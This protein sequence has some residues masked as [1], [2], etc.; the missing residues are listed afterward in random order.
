MTRYE[1]TVHY[2]EEL[3]RQS[4]QLYF[5]YRLRHD[6]WPLWLIMAGLLCIVILGLIQ[7]EWSGPTIKAGITLVCFP[8]LILFAYKAHVRLGLS[9]LHALETPNAT[10]V[11]TD[12]GLTA[13]SGDAGGLTP[14]T[15]FEAILQSQD[16]WILRVNEKSKLTLPTQGVDRSALEFIRSK[17]QGKVYAV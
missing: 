4:D 16:L 17:V 7:R 10:F 3:V 2:S 14:W 9:K 13:T 6:L 1:F 8:A 11:L 15:D 5:K 12:E